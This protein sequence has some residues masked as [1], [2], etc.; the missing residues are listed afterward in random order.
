MRENSFE[1][2]EIFSDDLIEEIEQL[3][4]KC[5]NTIVQKDNDAIIDQ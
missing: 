1:T 4:A 3:C 2:T 5:K